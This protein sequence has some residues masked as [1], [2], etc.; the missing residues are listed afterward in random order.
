MDVFDAGHSFIN[1]VILSYTYAFLT[2]Y[3]D[4][5]VAL[6]YTYGLWMV[7]DTR[8]SCTRHSHLVNLLG[9][10]APEEAGRRVLGWA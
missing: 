9:I 2:A 7:G 4:A 1:L 5:G 8:S 10:N 6:S 3:F